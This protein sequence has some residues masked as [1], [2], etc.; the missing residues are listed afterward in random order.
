MRFD[1][2]AVVNN[3]YSL[4]FSLIFWSLL[5]VPILKPD[6]TI[7]TI[8]NNFVGREQL[9][10][11]FRNLQYLLGDRVFPNVIVGKDGWLF[12]TGD[13]AID[14]YQ[15]TN[16]YSDR[17]LRDIKNNFD[18]LYDQLKKRG[19]MLLVVIPPDKGTIYPEYMPDQ[20]TKIG[21]K[22]RLDQF[23]NYMHEYGKTPIIDLRPDLIEASKNEQVFYKT[24]SHWNPNA[25]YIAYTRI[26]SVIS[27]QYP[28]VKPHPLS[29]Y[30]MLVEAPS[31]M[32][33]SKTMGIPNHK[34]AKWSYVPL[35]STGIST[36]IL[37]SERFS[38]NR[39]QDLPSALIFGDSFF[40]RLIPLLEPHFRQVISI[41]HDATPGMWN[42]DWADQ[43]H[44]D[45]VIIEYVQ[46]ALN[47]NFNIPTYK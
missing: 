8:G 21:S 7:N 17:E 28:E 23:V 4:L 29:D 12:Y 38:T 11:G 9:L 2:E 32:D 30:K 5:I 41:W 43:S 1:K 42:M 39:N 46:R 37:L 27:Q 47:Y 3:I 36:K 13:G 20:I 14:D 24:D 19:T 31:T 33:L 35:F 10:I 6:L 22:S 26:L 15:N 44:P 25:M 16:P 34:E 40:G 18:G 45:V